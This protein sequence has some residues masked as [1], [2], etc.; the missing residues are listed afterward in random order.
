VLAYGIHV[1]RHRLI[2]DFVASRFYN[3]FSLLFSLHNENAVLLHLFKK[4]C[5]QSRAQLIIGELYLQLVPDDR[6]ATNKIF[7]N[8]WIRISKVKQKKHGMTS[9]LFR[10]ITS[11]INEKEVSQQ[12]WTSLNIMYEKA[13][14]ASPE[15][16]LIYAL[17]AT[18]NKFI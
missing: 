13:H 5:S 16:T 15:R 14:L 6:H 3:S 17:K 8:Y 11:R 1:R 7:V 9:F 2:I 10:R 12:W 18:I 4:S